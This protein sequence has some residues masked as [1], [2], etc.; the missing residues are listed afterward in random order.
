M[1][2]LDEQNHQGLTL[3]LRTTAE[4]AAATDKFAD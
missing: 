4:D 3:T 2:F 1:L